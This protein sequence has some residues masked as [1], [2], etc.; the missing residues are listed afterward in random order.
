MERV[1]YVVDFCISCEINVHG[2]HSYIVGRNISQLWKVV[3][4]TILIVM[5]SCIK[6]SKQHN[7]DWVQ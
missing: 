6:V 3:A 7:F 1:Y 2:S 5:S 4:V